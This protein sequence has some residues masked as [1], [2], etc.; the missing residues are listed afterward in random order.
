M[1]RPMNRLRWRPATSLTQTWPSSR[2]STY[3]EASAAPMGCATPG[4]VHCDR[5]AAT[6][7][8]DEIDEGDGPEEPRDAPGELSSTK[9]NPRCI[10]CPFLDHLDFRFVIDD[11][12]R[13]CTC[14]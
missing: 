6:R 12:G 8:D 10:P 3:D 1:S 4:R 5:Q 2:L 11:P 14:P 13:T 7:L 9:T